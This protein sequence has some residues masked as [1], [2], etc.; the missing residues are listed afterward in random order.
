MKR[1]YYAVFGS[2]LVV[3]FLFF[4]GCGDTNVF[5]GMSDD[6]S[7]AARIEQAKQNLNS[8]NF[9]AVINSFKNKTGLTDRE[10]RYLAS[11]YMG[12]A[13]FDTLK[14]LEEIAKE[15]DTGEDVDT[16]DVITRIFDEDGDGCIT[17]EQMD[18][19]IN[20]INQALEV[21]GAP[22][23]ARDNRGSRALATSS[24][25]DDMKLQRGICAAIHA[26]FT[27]CQTVACQYKLNTIPLT[28][29]ALKSAIP[30]Q[31]IALTDNDCLS[32][33]A[34]LGRDLGW[35]QDAVAA[36]GGT[37]DQDLGGTSYQKNN[38]N[39]IQREFNSFLE[40]IGYAGGTSPNEVT[41]A[42][43]SAYLTR[44]LSK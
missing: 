14:L 16:F 19:K 22:G 43:L 44:L 38:E 17:S 28:V 41:S 30:G 42:E 2:L 18:T 3:I 29:D 7:E 6:S 35:V 11:A 13:G 4:Q 23:L 31:T 26:V 24:P 15:D 39:D 9:D 5:E 12:K 21:L 25:S 37:L 34:N 40:D 33:V 27:I 32:P 36:L 20:L 10:S 1:L 8:G